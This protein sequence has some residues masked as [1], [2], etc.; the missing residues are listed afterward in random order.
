MSRSR[1]S[2]SLLL[3][4]T[5]AVGVALGMALDRTGPTVTAQVAVARHPGETSATEPP[6][7]P[8]GDEAIYAQ[9]DR[10]YDRFLLVDRQFELVARAVAPSVVHIIARKK[11]EDKHRDGGWQSYEETGS[12]VIVRPGTNR[13]LYVLT[14]YHVIEGAQ[15][16]D[17]DITLQ[18][19]RVLRPT[20]VWLDSMADIAV[21]KLGRDDL[22]AA[23][24]GD[25]DKAPVG[26]WVLALGSPFGLTHSV[27]QGIISARNRY[28]EELEDVGVKNQD[29]LQTDAAI[30]PGNSGGPLVNMRGEVI[31]INQS[32][33]TNHGGS[34]GVGFSI[35]INLA[36]WVMTEL[37]TNGHVARGGMGVGLGKL[38]AERASELGLNCPRGACVLSVQHPSP[39]AKAGFQNGDVILRYDGREILDINH[40]INLVAMTPIGQKVEVHLWRGGELIVT[41]VAIANRE[42]IMA[43][44]PSA[45]PSANPRDESGPLRRPVRPSPAPAE[46]SRP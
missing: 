32:I 31:G 46:G 21:L 41:E 3:I 44:A 5:L 45:D 42:A 25:S 35:P 30:N 16:F 29:F 7:R 10:E 34:E 18:D 12:G 19:G 27:S 36:K 14:N 40:L 8:V 24:L 38:H 28:E 26:S 37:V 22:P 33:A 20:Q 9:L 1:F 11:D 15:T 17:I 2:S 6:S 13:D 23:R 4:T 39:A 43:L